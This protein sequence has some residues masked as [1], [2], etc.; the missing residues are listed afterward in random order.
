MLPSI[1][2]ASDP[3]VVSLPFFSDY[4]SKQ[5][6]D[7]ILPFPLYN[8]P[9]SPFSLYPEEDSALLLHHEPLTGHF[10][11][12]TK[13]DV[14]E[15]GKQLF[16]TNGLINNNSK[17]NET[18]QISTEKVIPK[19]RSTKRDRHSKINTVHGLRDRRMRLS[20]EVARKF[21]DL[22]DMLGFDKA[23]KTVEWLFT[24]SKPAID[25][26]SKS[27]SSCILTGAR[28]G[29]S[30]CEMVSGV[31]DESA[32]ACNG[33]DK[34]E[35]DGDYPEGLLLRPDSGKV[36]KTRR[37]H[38]STGRTSSPHTARESR[39]KARARAKERTREKILLRK[40]TANSGLMPFEIGGNSGKSP[41]GHDYM[42]LPF[43]EDGR[44]AFEEP[45]Q[46]RATREQQTREDPFTNTNTSDYLQSVGIIQDGQ[47]SDFQL[48]LK[49]WE[50]NC[51]TSYLF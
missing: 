14:T 40:L 1:P 50:A 8:F 15:A 32:D 37:S 16:D 46:V 4:N 28:A 10:L 20:L 11:P 12:N 13:T 7:L 5:D 44:A 42:K 23:S 17:H 19:K 48:F 31:I 47:F 36:I 3:S 45:K 43:A 26:L 22:Q 6:Q 9:L 2:N 34:R 39:E 27:S 18:S 33:R 51:G 29:E 30:E 38:P 25:H 35:K 41:L 21:F 24:H 49:P